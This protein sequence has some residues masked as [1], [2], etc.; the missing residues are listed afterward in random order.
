MINC[1]RS[2]VPSHAAELIRACREMKY[3]EMFGVDVDMDS[4]ATV[5]ELTEKENSL[6]EMLRGGSYIDVLTVHQGEPATA[7]ID[8]KIGGFR[9][10]RK[11]KFPTE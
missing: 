7:E 11:I 4:P 1:S 8:E 9:C 5:M 2:I 6:V 10:R 3:G